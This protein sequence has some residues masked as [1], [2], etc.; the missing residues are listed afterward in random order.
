M[1]I[2][3]IIPAR[4]GSKGVPG[5]NKKMLGG[6]PLVVRTINAAKA[7]ENIEEVFVSSDDLEIL[8]L[9][10]EWGAV[11]I[12]RPEDL[13]TDQMSSESALMHVLKELSA[14]GKTIETLVF[15]QCTSPFTTAVEIDSV[16]NEMSERNADSAF[17]AIE[18]HSFLWARDAT[19]NSIGLNHDSMKP[20]QR[21]QDMAPQYRENGAIYAM[22]VEKFLSEG[23][24]FCGK[25]VFVPVDGYDLEIDTQ[26]DWD[27]AETLAMKIDCNCVPKEKQEKIK[28]IIMDFDGVHTDD[29][30]IVSEN[31]I[32]AVICS[33]SDGMG[34]ELL[35]KQGMQLLILSKET[36]TVVMQRAN[37]L[38]IDVIHGVENKYQ[39]LSTWLSSNNLEWSEI[40]YVGNDINDIECLEKSGIGFVPQ[41]ANIKAKL[42]SDFIISKNGGDGA[43]RQM[44]EIFLAEHV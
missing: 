36:N 18:S 30:V 16:L 25:T 21:R 17:S 1:T 32:E 43:I 41:D 5:K 7:S 27:V 34:I 35:R 24:R 28:A 2:I 42:A 10:E 23:H 13:S 12:P 39:V 4:G 19:G 11:G 6:V 44:A 9:A 15:L 14:Q 33:R 3:A 38:N 20:R 40:A 26:L 8:S 22:N 29:R 37:K 31:G